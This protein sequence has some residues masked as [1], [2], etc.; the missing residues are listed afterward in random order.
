MTRRECLVYAV[1][2]NGHRQS[3]LD[4]LGHMFRLQPVSGAMSLR[5]YRRL[6]R[7]E[8]LLFATLDDDVLGFAAVAA[9]RSAL[10]RPTAALFLRANKC[11]ESGRWYYPCK[12]RAFRLMRRLSGMTIATITPFDVHPEYEEVAN[13]GVCDPQYWDMLSDGKIRVPAST[14][15]SYEVKSLA[16]GRKVITALGAIG[17]GKGFNFLAET[18]ER[19]PEL[20]QDVFIV[21]VGR[22]LQTAKPVA[23][24]FTDRGGLLIDRF[25]TDQELE[26]LYPVSDAIWACY[27]PEYDQASGIFGRAIQFGVPPLVRSGSGLSTFARKNELEHIPVEFG[28]HEHLADALRNL[29]SGCRTVDDRDKRIHRVAKWH[30]EFEHVIG[31]ALTDGRP[32]KAARDAG[33]SN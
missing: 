20:S 8:R 33:R 4:I 11:F 14:S 9:V 19:N 1:T 21:C 30:R 25:I 24:R 23:E 6:I 28:A 29:K 12:R 13:A 32:P 10:G 26:S 16:K 31:G 27:A 7:A 15:L 22:T 5:M 3:Y 2:T 17:P 18:L